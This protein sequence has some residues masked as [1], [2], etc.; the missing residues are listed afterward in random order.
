MKN[1]LKYILCSSLLVLSLASCKKNEWLNPNPLTLI[2]DET[3]FGSAERIGNQVNGLYVNLKATNLYGSWG[4]LLSDVRTG[5]F[6][7]S[8]MNG[9]T[10]AI[11]FSMLTQATTSDV[12]DVWA[13]GYLAINKVNVFLEGLESKGKAVLSEEQF[14]QYNAEA[15]LI[16]AT[17]YYLLLQLYARPYWD[18]KGSMPGLPLRLK[19][20]VG[21][22]NYDLKRSSVAETYKQIL[23]DLD[24]AEENLPSSYSSAALNTTRAHKNTAI[25]L[26]T[27]VYLSMGEYEKVITEADKI[28]P[29]A[30]PFV[31]PTGVANKLMGSIT[32]VFKAPYTSDESIF[33]M[34]FSSNDAPGSSLPRYYMPGLTDGG[35]PTSNG[36]GEYSLNV[37]EGIFAST[38]WAADDDRRTSFVKVGQQ[39]G[40]PWLFKFYQASPYLDYI[41]V[42]RYAEVVLNLSEA[43]A[44]SKKS[45]DSR[46]IA[47]F[48]AVYSRSNQGKT[49]SSTDFGTLETYLDRII[50]ERR[51]EFLG[52]GIRNGDIMRLGQT[53]PSK[54]KQSIPAVA[55]TEPNY[56]F[57]IPN[58]E[59]TLNNLIKND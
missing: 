49:Y 17:S 43:L 30:A 38:T 37:V 7:S 5:E 56:I 22:G 4:V 12:E 54:V 46:S 23:D 25:A 40:R 26:K 9:A 2:T 18:G 8:N 1:N 16:R 57:P 24:F 19:G 48:N 15:R 27:R 28:V 20:N 35:T 31:A 33:S 34:P 6:H 36:A 11:V 41:P 52:E 58:S 47:L 3:A 53:I 45:I 13:A 50:E 55:P 10:G 32:E 14:N 44:R 39:S 51:I 21:P 29:A 59:L 42:I